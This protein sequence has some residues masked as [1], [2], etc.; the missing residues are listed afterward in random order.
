MTPSS[1]NL[2]YFD[3][4]VLGMNAVNILSCWLLM[5]AP[6]MKEIVRA[7]GDVELDVVWSTKPKLQEICKI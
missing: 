7:T 1:S 6:W 2:D 4:N 5:L 3:L